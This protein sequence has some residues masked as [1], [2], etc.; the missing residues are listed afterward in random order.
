[1]PLRRSAL[2]LPLLVL[3][4]CVATALAPLGAAGAAESAPPGSSAERSAA[5]GLP[6]GHDRIGV[7]RS[8]SWYLR[9]DLGSG[10][11]RVV[12]EHVGG[13]APVAG[14]WD[15]DGT[16]TTGLFRN[17]EWRLSGSAGTTVFRFGMPGD[18]PVVG[19]WDADGVD[20]VGVYRGGRFYLRDAPGG[21][22]A[23]VVGFGVPGDVPVVGDW[24]GD[25]GTDIGVKRGRTWYQRD[26]SDPGAASRSF[27][28]GLAADLPVAGDWDHDGR[29]TVAA[30]RDGTWFLR[31]G[32][33]GYQQVRFGLKG[34]RPVVRRTQG[35][36]PG[37]SHRVLR[38]P[39]G[40]VAHVVTVQLDATS[41]PDVVLARDAL[42]GTEVTSSMGRRSG[43]VVAVNGDYAE[44]D[45]RP[46]HSLGVDGRLVASS[47]L[48]GKALGLS[49]AGT[50]VP[51][52]RPQLSVSVQPEGRDPVPV[53]A[54]NDGQP[55]GDE[56]VAFTGD[57]APAETPRGGACYAGLAPGTTV[58][59]EGV[60]ETATSVTGR[61]CF[62]DPPVVPDTGAML[63]ANT[64]FAQQPLFESLSPG[65]AATVRTT[66]GFPGAVD[67]LG[68]NPMLVVDGAVV[69]AD[70]DRSGGYFDPAP[71]TAVGLTAEGTLLLVVVDGRRPGYSSGA[72]LRQLA[73]HMAALG[74]RQALNLDGGGSSTMWLNGV[75]AN[76]PSDGAE[77]G[78]S[79]ALVVLPAG[80]PGQ[81]GVQEAAQPGVLGR[82]ADT[83][84]T[85]PVP[86]RAVPGPA[87]ST[88]RAL[89]DPASTGGLP[90]R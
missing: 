76:R 65:Q 77:R 80:D 30:F 12:R 47:D 31:D 29:D 8:D 84:V 7:R 81:A 87:D 13:Y 50:A 54:W 69:S 2:L 20:T 57:G 43:A 52:G 79:S 48:E 82:R 28:F 24:D 27:A 88:E 63:T 58:V 9:P 40:F 72:S 53:R 6:L 89:R 55:D 41:T 15:G 73:D 90:G 74:A 38:D 49:L 26:A 78:V 51:M 16:G 83:P 10:A 33:G 35:L 71:R 17:G 62:G 85:Q 45:G 44:R 46:V 3:P 66:L 70:V 4:A 67:L 75:V 59:R 36:A 60:L 42:L 22:P 23:R 86:V 37:V 56:V 18:L 32:G 61:R 64:Y 14:D 19:D 11:A 68:G 5:L 1:V 25:G 39:A 34:D 21:G